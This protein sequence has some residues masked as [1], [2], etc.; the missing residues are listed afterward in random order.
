MN[1]NDRI[2]NLRKTGMTFSKIASEVGVSSRTARRVAGDIVVT[3]NGERA[4]RNA[5]IRSLRYAGLTFTDVASMVGVSVR[6][7]R[8]VA[9]DVELAHTNDDA[10]RIVRNARIRSLRASGMTFEEIA[11][12]VGVSVRTVRRIAGDVEL[13]FADE[14]FFLGTTEEEAYRQ[15]CANG[16]VPVVYLITDGEFCKVGYSS[17]LL[18]ERIAALQTGNARKLRVIGA[19]HGTTEDEANIHDAFADRRLQGEWFD[20]GISEILSINGR[21]NIAT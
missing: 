11:T 5:R 6:T 16:P 13:A 10:E 17:T 21:F 1:R 12:Q 3:D 15:L 9:G 20:L 8:R 19:W 4:A 2:R 18:H 14:S 7:V